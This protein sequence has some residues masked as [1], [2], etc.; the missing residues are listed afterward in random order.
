MSRIKAEKYG[1]LLSGVLLLTTIL[2]SFAPA[3]ESIK[4]TLTRVDETPTEAATREEV[5]PKRQSIHSDTPTIISDQTREPPPQPVTQSASE[6]QL[7]PPTLE[8][9]NDEVS[10]DPHTRPHSLLEFASDLAPKM[11]KA[12]ESEELASTF[13]R[14]LRECALNSTNPETIRQ[15]CLS[16]AKLLF[17]KYPSFESEWP[18]LIHDNKFESQN[19]TR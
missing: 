19:I 14:E 11:R 6:T 2:Y 4:Q 7:H 17:E 13:F 18:E 9:I 1:F 5:T 10:K 3:T 8:K 12:Y 16:N 15:I